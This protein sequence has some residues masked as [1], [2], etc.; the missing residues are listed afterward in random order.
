MAA[1]GLG[2]LRLW[3]TYLSAAVGTVLALGCTAIVAFAVPGA[4]SQHS[5]LY[6]ALVLFCINGLGFGLAA[7]TSL[8]PRYAGI[9]R[10][11]K[12]YGRPIVIGDMQVT[13]GLLAFLWLSVVRAI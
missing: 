6:L 3:E 8:S 7:L 1:D 13:M 2:L 12:Q 10:F 4:R 9:K 11:Y 5:T